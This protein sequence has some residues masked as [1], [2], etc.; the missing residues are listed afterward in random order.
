ML[1]LTTKVVDWI[2]NAM[3]SGTNLKEEKKTDALPLIRENLLMRKKEKKSSSLWRQ[4]T[5]LGLFGE[6]LVS[7][8]YLNSINTCSSLNFIICK[9]TARISKH[10]RPKLKIVLRNWY[11]GEL[12]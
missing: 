9:F 7:V 11:E 2:A 10:R 12:G 5:R 6:G 4:K 1:I 3:F 8:T